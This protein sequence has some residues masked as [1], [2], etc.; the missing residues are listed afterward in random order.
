MKPANHLCAA[1]LLILT[2]FTSCKKESATPYDPESAV[3]VTF[4]LTND[5]ATA[6]L[7]SEDDNDL[8][9]EAAEEKQLLGN[10]DTET[11][12]SN[13]L[14]SCATITVTPQNNFPKTIVIDYGPANCIDPK[15]VARRG[16]IY[17]TLSDTLRR[18]GST[19]VMTFDGYHINEF[20]REG[21]H[22]WTNKSM[23]ITRSWQRKFE[24]GKITA[25]G[26][27]SWFHQSLREVVQTAGV[28]TSKHLSDD[29]F[30]ITGHSSVTNPANITRTAT[31]LEPLQKKYSCPFIDKGKVKFQGPNHFAVLNYGDGDCDRFATISVDGRTPRIIS[32]R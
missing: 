28:A 4:E 13:N 20:K 5:Q 10:F 16:K 25:P 19:A 6:D 9:F 8:L 23:G 11:L 2:L 22:T 17:I 26:G 1:T 24:N 3:E 18:P 12:E 15:A 30:S 7:L 27:R 31:I 21:T 32:L 29:E 14:L